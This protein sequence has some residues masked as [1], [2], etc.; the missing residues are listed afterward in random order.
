MVVL[1]CMVGVSRADRALDYAAEDAGYEI[2]QSLS[3]TQLSV[4]PIAF[5]GFFGDKAGITPVLEAEM[6]RYSGPFEFFTRKEKDWNVLVSEIEFGERKSDIMDQATIQKFGSIQGVSA[7]LYGDI[8]EVSVVDGVGTVRLTVKLGDVQTGKILWSAN[9]EGAYAGDL[10]AP[11]RRTA[12]ALQEAAEKAAASLAGKKAGLGRINVYLMPMNA[13]GLNLSDYVLPEFTKV[14][15]EKVKMFSSAGGQRGRR[16]VNKIA[17]QLAA[18]G[19]GNMK[20]LA[21][22]KEELF[23]DVPKEQGVRDAVLY[24]HIGDLSTEGVVMSTVVLNLHIADML[25]GE[26]I[27]GETVEGRV[28]LDW[29]HIVKTY[30]I[31]I[32]VGIA[33]VVSIGIFLNA[34]RRVR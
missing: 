7:L 29:L 27:W 3:N 10:K 19:S 20:A 9:I 8:R 22:Q 15:D 32:L 2:I 25:T 28:E 24:G 26:E 13:N 6:T 31:H 30:W 21:A 5:L 17:S 12:M 16:I 11:D 4:G 1:L 33:A 23:G 14:G 18:S 34:T